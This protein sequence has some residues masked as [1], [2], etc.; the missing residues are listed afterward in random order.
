MSVTLRLAAPD[1]AA[2]LAE[3]LVEAAFWRPGGRRGTVADVLSQPELAHYVAGWPMP[4]DL[5]V[6]AEDDHPVGAAWLR[7][8]PETDPG[9][10]FV[11]AAIPEV[12]TGIDSAW[13]GR[14]VGTRLLRALIG[15]ARERGLNGLSL[16]VESDNYACRLYER[17]GFRSIRQVGGSLTMLLDLVDR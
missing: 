13:R 17:L 15:N 2:F 5:G 11:D 10:G 12:A 14:G 16:S 1:D 9:Y 7:F 4:G 3:M 8:L 6:I